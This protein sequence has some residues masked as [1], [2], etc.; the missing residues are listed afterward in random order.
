MNKNKIVLSTV[1]W[2]DEFLKIFSNYCLKSL[3]LEGNIYSKKFNKESIFLIFTEKKNIEAIKKNKYYLIIKNKI[4]VVF[5]VIRIENVNKYEIVTKYQKI[6][7]NFCKKKKGIF[8]H[9]YPDSILEKNYIK[10]CLKKINQGYKLILCPGPLINLEDY[11]YNSG[12]YT[13]EK[14]LHNFYRRFLYYSYT[15]NIQIYR[16]EKHYLFKCFHCHIA[17]ADLNGIDTNIK[18]TLDED[19][20]SKYSNIS[21]IYYSKNKDDIGIISL[22]SIL[23]ERGL[24]YNINIRKELNINDKKY[25]LALLNNKTE[26]EI[27]NFFLGNFSTSKN[28]KLIKLVKKSNKLFYSIINKY[29][30]SLNIKTNK[31]KKDNMIKFFQYF[32]IAKF[33]ALLNLNQIK[34]SKEDLHKINNI[35]TVTENIFKVL[36]NKKISFYIYFGF[37][38]LIFLPIDM[39]RYLINMLKKYKLSN[40]DRNSLPVYEYLAFFNYNQVP[41]IF[42]LKFYIK[43]IFKKI[44][45]I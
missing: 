18:S 2:G 1:F 19:L 12:K 13:I 17:A 4:K 3:L 27:R 10:N 33:E 9:I 25:I 20:I 28:Y 36:H 7:L 16:L 44:K 8:I 35:I 14:N 5:K 6:I 32:D 37:V 22:E 15:N 21:Q 45:I 41:K 24:N 42:L 40:Y 23:T 11:I 26:Y 43:T 31:S 29:L 38:I 30:K 34:K 39:Q